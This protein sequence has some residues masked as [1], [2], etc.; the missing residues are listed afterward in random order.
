MVTRSKHLHDFFV[1]VETVA[2]K[3]AEGFLVLEYS[4][5]CKL[6]FSFP[7]WS[8]CVIHPPDMEYIMGLTPLLSVRKVI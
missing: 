6:G 5:E 4:F 8:L 2:T 3:V 7:Y 1:V